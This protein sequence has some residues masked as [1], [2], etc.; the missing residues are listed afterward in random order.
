MFPFTKKKHVTKI[1]PT[2]PW[3]APPLG[4]I[5]GWSVVHKNQRPDAEYT[6]RAVGRFSNGRDCLL[7]ESAYG[8]VCTCW[9]DAPKAHV[10]VVPPRKAQRVVA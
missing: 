3:P 8:E 1:E 2:R 10:W 9:A 6:L 4:R 7:Y 5:I